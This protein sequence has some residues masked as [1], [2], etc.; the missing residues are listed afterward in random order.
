MG[1]LLDH[2]EILGVPP[3]ASLEEIKTAFRHAALRL[4]PDKKISTE[5]DTEDFIKIQQAWD[6][7][8]SSESRAVYDVQRATAEARAAVHITDT[9]LVGNMESGTTENGEAIVSYPCRCGGTY[10]VLEEELGR[11]QHDTLSADGAGEIEKQNNKNS[12]PGDIVVPCS[13]CSL[14]ILVDLQNPNNPA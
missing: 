9:I 4:H 10:A 3:T 2:Y 13:T 12:P 11:Q 7:L 1:L 6:V 8:S 14:H 5:N